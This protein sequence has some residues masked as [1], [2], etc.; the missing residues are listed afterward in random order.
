[1]LKIYTTP[2]CASCRKAK[3]WLDE[4]N[5]SYEEK[6]I[7]AFPITK[8][9]IRLMLKNTENG[10][11]DIISTR[12]KYIQEN[13]IDIDSMKFSELE[14]L[15]IDNPS[16][17]KRPIIVDDNKLQI[18]YN[19]EDIRVFIPKELRKILMNLDCDSCNYKDE[20]KKYYYEHVNVK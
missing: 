1:M 17:L 8:E 7:F 13:N 2:S 14:K 6:N 5:I 19:E 16:I 20:L 10:F 15:I 9:D 12:S 11:E 3:N 18:G 4:H